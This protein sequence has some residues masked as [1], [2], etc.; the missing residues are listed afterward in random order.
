MTSCAGLGLRLTWKWVNRQK[1]K[2]YCVLARTFVTVIEFESVK[3]ALT[4]TESALQAV[5]H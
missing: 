4:E 5:C 1:R 2:S 3:G